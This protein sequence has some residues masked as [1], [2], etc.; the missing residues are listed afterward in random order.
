M[1]KSIALKPKTDESNRF[2]AAR[3]LLKEDAP[4]PE[5]A[6]K[7]EAPKRGRTP[8]STEASVRQ[9]FD[10]PVSLKQEMGI[11]VAGSSRFKSHRDFLIQCVKDGLEKYKGQ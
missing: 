9:N 2:Q 6:A 10:C 3:Q 7:D 4:A 11:F 8:A 5:K 1:S